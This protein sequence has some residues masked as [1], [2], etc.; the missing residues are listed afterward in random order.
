MVFAEKVN[1]QTHE[2]LCKLVERINNGPLLAYAFIMSDEILGKLLNKLGIDAE[3]FHKKGY[4]YDEN[5]KLH[6]ALHDDGYVWISTYG[7][8][9]CGKISANKFLNSFSSQFITLK[10]LLD[11]ALKLCDDEDC[12]NIN[13]D[14]HLYLVSISLSVYSNLIFFYELFC[15]AYLSEMGIEFKFI[16]N[17]S[18]LLDKTKDTV[19]QKGHSDTLLHGCIIPIIERIAEHIK[20]MPEKFKEQFIKYDDNKEDSTII[21]FSKELITN[22]VNDMKI[23]YEFINELA[24]CPEDAIYLRKGLFDRLISMADSEESKEKIEDTYSF[25]QR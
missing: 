21:I 23:C 25:L 20:S 13:S 4:F 8:I 24:E 16:H 9:G 7:V 12:L 10:L 14:K 15:K 5:K 6:I 17:I 19:K 3:L 2:E 11:E 1:I 22:T 18:E